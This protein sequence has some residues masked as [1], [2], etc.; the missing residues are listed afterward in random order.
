MASI[1]HVVGDSKYG[2]GAVLIE[3]IATAA[4]H[5]GHQTAVL[6]TDPVFQKRLREVGIG[7]VDLEC[8][9]RPIRL[10]KDLQGLIRLW[11]YLS[12]RQYNLVHTHTSKAGF[13]GRL[14]ARMARVPVV[15]HTVHGFA[16]HEASSKTALLGYSLLEWI[17][18]HFCDALVTV[19]RFHCDWAANLHIGS[20]R[21][22][23]AIPNG[24]DPGRIKPQR[25][26][27]KVR[28]DLGIDDNEVLCLTT[29]RLVQQKGLDVLMSAISKLDQSLAVHFVIVGDGEQSSVL[30]RLAKVLKIEKRISFL[31][32]RTDLGDLL[33]AA[34]L[35]VLPSLR[36]GLSIS[37]LE[38]MAAGKPIITTNIGSNLEVTAN[39]KAAR[40]V[41]AGNAQSLADAI[42]YLVGDKKECERL[43]R[44]ALVEFEREYHEDIMS[45]RYMELYARLLNEKH[46]KSNS[47][48][49]GT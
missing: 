16:F 46:S 34:D 33:A 49:S 39:G 21:T 5:A 17:A 13:V 22:R 44:A 28:T 45:L 1:L 14:A 18:A 12:R 4:V 36:E 38:A 6:T 20:K 42:Y 24:I 2:G 9:W 40:L 27:Q 32:F 31:G 37:L 15:V 23:I 30:E 19:S 35:I 25:S 48:G 29:G 11:R 3:R 8:I 7:I 43:G 41:A 26:R 47:F 10:H